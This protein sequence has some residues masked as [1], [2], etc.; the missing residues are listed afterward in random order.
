MNRDD[1]R[2]AVFTAFVQADVAYNCAECYRR[3]EGWPKQMSDA[4]HDA[5]HV[6]AETES[7][8]HVAAPK[9]E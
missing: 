2:R 6:V 9:G 5:H 7:Y 3:R 8:L 1:L 4:E